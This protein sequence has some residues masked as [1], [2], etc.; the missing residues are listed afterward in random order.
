MD[1]AETVKTLI[2]N[3]G[4]LMKA[5]PSLNLGMPMK[6][7]TGLDS[8]LGT[9]PIGSQVCTVFYMKL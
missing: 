2:N 1:L 8:G 4:P 6:R 3:H 5:R 7:P 9:P